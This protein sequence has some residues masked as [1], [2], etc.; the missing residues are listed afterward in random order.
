AEI[1]IPKSAMTGRPSY[2]YWT[3]RNNGDFYLLQSLFEDDRDKN[4]IFFNS[5]IVR[6]TEGLLFGANLYKALD[7]PDETKVSVRVAHRGFAGRTLSSSN[8]Q[9]HILPRQAVED[10]SETEIVEEV[11]QLRMHLVD[12][13]QHLL[14]PLFTLFDFME[15]DHKVYEQIVTDFANGHST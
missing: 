1:S 4:A 7:V 12:N 8:P 3:L 10:V 2:D 6:V 5:R 15:F 14:E 13:V 11:G 9:R